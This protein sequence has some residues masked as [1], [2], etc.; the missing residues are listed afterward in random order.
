MAE[1]TPHTEPTDELAAA[2]GEL[3]DAFGR[4]MVHHRRTVQRQAEAVSPGL[5]PAAM[6][7]FLTVCRQGRTTPSAL[8]DHLL[9]DRGQVSRTVGELEGLGLVS[10]SPDP[11]DRRQTLVTP[12]EEGLARLDR[13]RGGAPGEG[14]R[15]ALAGWEPD[16]VRMLATLLHRFVA[17]WGDEPPVTR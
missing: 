14:L 7:A 4:L 17:G 12:T 8:A 15:R 10:R 6:K 5:P 16:E 13:A 2:A 11:E 3:E 1:P 9:M